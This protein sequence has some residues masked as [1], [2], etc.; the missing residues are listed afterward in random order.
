MPIRKSLEAKSAYIYQEREDRMVDYRNFYQSD[1]F[2]EF[3]NSKQYY[4][5]VFPQ[6]LFIALLAA[7]ER[8]WIIAIISIRL[9]WHRARPSVK[10]FASRQPIPGF[11]VTDR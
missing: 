6:I 4:M 9:H 1:A 2:S 7:G 11:L 10:I 8:K 3:K 5:R